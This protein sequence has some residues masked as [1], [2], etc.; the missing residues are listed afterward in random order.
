M[1]NL[2]AIIPLMFF[3]A[4]SVFAQAAPTGP[5]P[6]DRRINTDRVRQQD[7]SNREWQLRNFG[8][9]AG[10]PKDKRT[11]EALMAQT[12]EDF[13]RILTLH[14]EIARAVKSNNAL[15]YGFVS[16]ATGEIKKRASRVQSS[17]HLGLSPEETANAEKPKEFKD[18]KEALVTL[19]KQIRSFVT[20]PVIANP[21]T[22]NV[23]ESVRARRDLESVIHL[24]DQIKKDAD[25]LGN[26]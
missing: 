7:M 24:S 10:S 15:D 1:K 9:D 4:A 17:L 19:C 16:N 3:S 20:N 23:D 12:E 18:T 13:N 26:N 11:V 2:L 8:R 25:K 5:P 21:N 6:A 14:N 22:I